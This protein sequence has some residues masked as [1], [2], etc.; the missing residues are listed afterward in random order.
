MLKPEVSLTVGL[1]TAAMVYGVYMNALPPVIDI[2]STNQSDPQVASTEKTAAWTSA[3]VVAGVSLIAKDPTVFVL[4][5]SMVVALAW[6]YRHANEVNPE[7]GVAV[8][9]GDRLP[10]QF[11]E[12]AMGDSES[13]DES[14]NYAFA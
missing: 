1:A 10:E 4:G 8:P 9:T 14:P 3:A 11:D 6:W 12:S 13:Y 5:G 2:R 7:F